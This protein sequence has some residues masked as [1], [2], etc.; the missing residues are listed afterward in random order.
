MQETIYNREYKKTGMKGIFRNLD[1]MAPGFCR[2]VVFARSCAEKTGTQYH[3][4]L[5]TGKLLVI[6]LRGS[7]TVNY[8]DGNGRNVCFIQHPGSVFYFGR[9]PFTI[10]FESD[11]ER[12]GI[13]LQDGT[14]KRVGLSYHN[15]QSDEITPFVPDIYAD[16]RLEDMEELCSLFHLL[17][18]RGKLPERT[19][20]LTCR[21]PGLIVQWLKEKLASS[22]DRNRLPPEKTFEMLKNALDRNFQGEISRKSLAYEFSFSEDYITRL[23]KRYAGMGVSEYL[24]ERRMRLALYL[25]QSNRTLSIVKAAGYCGYDSA[26]YFSKV[27]FRYWKKLPKEVRRSAP[28]PEP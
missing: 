20:P 7:Q 21:I 23:F 4:R 25:L 9:G 11:V 22:L 3:D 10:S 6:L 14:G 1:P 27:F 15:H 28:M 8:P 5:G 18:M 17:E 26:D 2:K 16:G 12:I 24:T 19:D 13:A